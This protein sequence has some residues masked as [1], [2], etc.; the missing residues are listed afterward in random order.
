MDI[1]AMS[2]LTQSML[3]PAMSAA[4]SP[5]PSP[6]ASRPADCSSTRPRNWLHVTST[7]SSSASRWRQATASG[8]AVARR[9]T[10][11]PTLG[12][13][14]SRTS[15]SMG[16]S[17]GVA[18]PSMR[19]SLPAPERALGRPTVLTGGGGL[20]SFCGLLIVCLSR[21]FSVVVVL[22]HHARVM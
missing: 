16:S 20:R 11:A 18:Y 5:L 17:A 9:R 2:E 15:R 10:I 6:A 1:S 13:G 4:V 12:A 7:H 22:C 21:G 8:V 14:L 19:H 3:V